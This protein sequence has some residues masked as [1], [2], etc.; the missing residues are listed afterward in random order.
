MEAIQE[1]TTDMLAPLDNQVI[2]KIAFTDMEVFTG[3]VKDILGIDIEVEKIETEKKFE[4]KIG[5]IDFAY[6][7]FAESKDHRVI[8]EI[9]KAELDYH[10]DRFL[11]YH[12]MAVAELQRRA[13][14]YKIKQ[15]VYT[16]VMLTAPYTIEE[17]T[18]LPIKNEVLVSSSDPRDLEDKIIP[19]YG[20]KLVFLNPNHKQEMTPQNYRDWLDLVYESI[21]NSE[22]YL[23]NMENTAIKKAV[24]LIEYEKLSP[25]Q[26]R[27]MKEDASRRATLAIY[28]NKLE[29]VSQDLEK[30]KQERKQT[31][32]EL[33][34]EKQA[35]RQERKKAEQD[36]QKAEQ[37]LSKEKQRV[38]V[39]AKKLKESGVPVLEIMELTGLSEKEI[40]KI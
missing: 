20:H 8:V 10:F 26:I 37:E 13:A 6:D 27:E 5:N 24:G 9:Q 34:K 38:F 21:H 12:Y 33:S 1:N 15:T 11:H 4:P 19:I 35:R 36:K 40:D 22:K 32:Q 29:K 14:D 23:V 39:L 31:E 18:G 16:I 7:I 2:F 3:F 25:K 28:E 17:R 30:E